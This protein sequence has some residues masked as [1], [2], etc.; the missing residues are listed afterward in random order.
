MTAKR[1]KRS[2]AIK[3]VTVPATSTLFDPFDDGLLDALRFA[4]QCQDEAEIV[5]ACSRF[6]KAARHDGW[7][8]AC[9][10]PHLRVS[11]HSV[12]HVS[13]S[14]YDPRW[15]ARYNANRHFDHDPV[16]KRGLTAFRPFD[17]S[18]LTDLSPAAL[19][20]FSE[21]SGFGILGGLSAPVR[22]PM[23]ARGLLNLSRATPEPLAGARRLV[24]EAATLYFGTLLMES[25]VRV[26]DQVATDF[27][28]VAA[29]LREENLALLAGMATG[30]SN[31]ALARQLGIS[32]K[33]LGQ[34]IDR[35]ARKL[36][37][38]SREQALARAA[39]LD[40]I[41]NAN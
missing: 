18:E 40:L 38:R 22:G 11:D 35:V 1:L 31:D 33:T 28:G 15:I 9:S 29:D 8:L 5:S 2:S 39:F 10:L 36:G 23:G 21:A 14:G 26:G 12:P 41:P 30:L 13:F 27:A 24:I 3:P 4:D 16:V 17:W 6:C 19:T 32:T 25:V 7:L 34:R 37:C 20:L